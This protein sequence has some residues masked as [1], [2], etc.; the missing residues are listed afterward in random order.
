MTGRATM[1]GN[2]TMTGRATGCQKKVAPEKKG[3]WPFSWSDRPDYQK[4]DPEQVWA[5]FVSELRRNSRLSVGPRR[6]QMAT[7]V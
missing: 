6:E 3:F 7:F 5:R 4:N 2:A 1:T